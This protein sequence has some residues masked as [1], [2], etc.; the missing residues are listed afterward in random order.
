MLEVAGDI[1]AS[2]DLYLGDDIYLTSNNAS[3]YNIDTDSFI[4]FPHI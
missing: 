2:G 3:I 1:S 4:R